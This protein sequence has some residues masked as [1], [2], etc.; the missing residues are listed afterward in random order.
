MKCWILATVFAILASGLSYAATFHG[1]IS[2]SSCALN[3]HSLSR[4]HKEMLKSRSF[5]AD[6]AS[7]SRHC[8]AQFAASFVLVDKKNVY[9]LDDQVTA[10]KWAGQAVLVTGELDVKKN[11]ITV[12]SIQAASP[13]K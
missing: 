10:E 13:A 1:E 7:C 6:A 3:V 12:T 4:S 5:G 11:V 8:A 9:R 2:D